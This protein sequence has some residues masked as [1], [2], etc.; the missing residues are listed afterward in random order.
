MAK[1]IS[2][3]DIQDMSQDWGLDES[4]GLPYSG[5]AVQKFIK[6]KLNSKMGW[7]HYD[8]TSNRYL[9]FADE[10]SKDAYVENPTRTDLV[11]GTFDAPF[12][13]EASIVLE[14]SAYNA[15]SLGSTGHYIDFTFDI[16]NKTG[17]STGESV[18]CTYTFRRGSVKQTV[19]EQ[20][21][22]GTSVHFNVDKYLSEGT[23]T[24]I[25]A[26]R[27]T[28]TLAATTASVTYQVVN[29]SISTELD[30]SQV[31][32][33]TQG[34]Q[35]M[36]VPFSV[37]GYGTKTV[38]WYLDGKKQN[39]VKEE[40][41]VV[42]VSVSR[43][44]Y[45]TLSN[46]SQ[47]VHTLQ[48]RAGTTVE[49]DSFY[50]D[51]LYREILVYTNTGIDTMTA[52]AM[53]VPAKH[54][55]LSSRKLYGMVQYVPYVLTFATYTPK[56]AA[57]DVDV[58]IDGVSQGTVRSEN[59]VVNEF[60][61]A[62]SASGSATIA[63]VT[64]GGSSSIGAVI[65][66]TTLNISEIKDG[67][68]LNFRAVGKSNN[69]TDKDSWSDGDYSGT[70]DGFN[71][72]NTSGWVDNSLLINA[73]ASFGI[74]LAP[75]NPNPSLLG[76]TIEI[77][78][79]TTNVHND[80]AVICDLRGEN[81][82]GILITATKV[83]LTSD[84]GVT[85]DTPFKDNEVNRFAFVINKAQGTTNKCMSFIYVNGKV[86]RG[87]AWAV[88]DRYATSKTLLFRGTEDAEIKL[89]AIRI[90]DAALTSDQLL[91]NYT[92]YRDN[93]LDMN[94]VYERN[95]VYA[96]GT[97]TFDYEKMVGR[98]PV[99]IVTGNIPVLENTTDKNEQITVDIDYHNIQHPELSFSWKQAAFRP[100]GTS[101]MG[102]PKKNFRPY[103]NKLA[104]TVCYDASGNKVEDRL[105]AFKEGA[106]RV[107]CWCLKADYAESSGTHNT[108][109]ARLWNNVLMNATVDGKYVFRTEA[110]K[111]AVAAGF[112]YDVRTTIDG[113]PILLFYRLT[114][115]DPLV[116]IGKYNFNND[117]STP[118][119]F[120][121][122]GVPGFDNRNMQCWEVLN[123][124][125]ALALF[126]TADGFDTGWS[127]AFESRYP[128]TKNPDTTK[129]KA[130]C[131]WMS[132]VS[133]TNF[134]TQKWD[135]FNV[136][137]LAAYYVYLMRFGAVD[138][139][140]K[141]AMLT[142]EDGKH[143][144]F[145]NYD[146]D[147]INGLINTGKLAVPWNADRK[148]IGEDG[149]PY[150]AGSQSRLWN[151]CEADAEFMSVVSKV[152]EALYTAGLKYAD[153]VKMF[154][155]EQADK[156]VER[157]YNQDAQY[158]YIGPYVEKGID[159]LFM[160]Q[161]DRSTHRKWWLARR[162]N[163]FDSKFI[164]GAYKAQSVEL[165]CINNTT[166][167]QKITITAGTAM[168]Y[169]YGINNVAREGN[170]TLAEGEQHTFTTTETVNLGDPIRLYAAANIKGIDLSKMTDRLAVV[171]IDKVY[172][173]ALG[174]K[175]THLVVGS[176]TLTNTSVENISGLAQAVKLEHLDVQNMKGMKALDLTGQ[177]NIRY[178][179]T[180][181]SGIGSV[182]FARGAALQTFHLSAAAKAL[183][184]VQLPYLTT[185]TSE[186]DF[187]G[188]AT[189]IV[190]KCPTLSR[191]FTFVYDWFT[192]A[193]AKAE[194]LS[195]EMDEIAWEDVD[196]DRLIEMGAIGQKSLKGQVSLKS[197]T[198]EQ[199]V[200]L[201]EIYG[202][203]C[204]SRDNDFFISAPD[205]VFIVSEDS[206]IEG[207]KLQLS[208]EIFSDSPGTV[209]W[210]IIGGGT[211]YQSIDNDGLLTTR[212]SGSART[213]TVQAR[214]VPTQGTVVHDT[215][216]ITV[217]KAV[218]PTGGTISGLNTVGGDTDFTLSVSPEGINRSYSVAWN[219]SGAGFDNGYVGIKTQN[220][221][222]CTVEVLSDDAVGDVTLNA[223][224]TCDNLQTVI[225]SKDLTIGIL[226]TMNILS[227]Q[228]TDTV[229]SA[230]KATVK[231]G[232][233]SLKVGN[234]ESIGVPTSTVLTVTFPEVEGYKSPDDFELNSGTSSFSRSVYYK[235]ELVRV[236]LSAWDG[237]SVNGK[238]VTI[239]GKSHA[240]GG[241]AIEQKVPFD[242]FYS[243]T[244]ELD[245]NY[246]SPK[247]EFTASQVRR[248]VELMY[249][250]KFGSWIKINQTI[251][252]SATMITGNINGEHIQRIRNHSHRYLGKY[253]AEGTMTI[254]QLDDENST[255]YKDGTSATLSGAEGD[256]FMKLPRFWY[257]CM[258]LATNVWTIGFYHGT[259]SPGDGWM[260]WDGNDLIGVYESYST[261]NKAYSRSGVPSTG[262]VSQ[263]SWKTYAR[264][265]G[266]GFSIVKW[267]HHCIMAA[268]YYAMYGNTNCQALIGVGTDSYS[269]SMGQTN[270]LGMEDTKAETNGNTQSINFWG[271]EN[272]WGNKS[273]WIDN[274]VVDAYKW[275]VTEDDGSERMAGTGPTTNGWISKLLF[276]ER[277]D[278]IPQEVSGS[279]TSGFCD[280][281]Y[282]YPSSSRVVRRSNGYSSPNGGV[283]FAYADGVASGAYS[284]YASRLAFRG[285][286]VEAESVAAFKAAV[287]IG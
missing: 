114:Q 33:L 170:I 116:F 87:A 152:D 186:D 52:I 192:H 263:S 98:L 169:G 30:I 127:E 182:E 205:G 57:V 19:T 178:V 49:G 219:L 17:L 181:G 247:A 220:D 153:V 125:N 86:S 165:K 226:F 216:Q 217:K 210:S 58:R 97:N 161:G 228:G 268:L 54:G 4:N 101:S 21:A 11:L 100:Q 111:A 63:F 158:K 257:R 253:T 209:T 269:K 12:N 44:K 9:C 16:R 163:Y 132:G 229:I 193:S 146:N 197:M 38:E 222:G 117:K 42:D 283:A 270:S 41:E 279:S 26:V 172:D 237:G 37:S 55:I 231:F 273:E 85:I 213:I 40:D 67:L 90:Y 65:E 145:I 48:M 28:D 113:F 254:C 70:F 110:Q 164:S 135:H 274:V 45:I 91:N 267:K 74:N 84:A 249:S 221:S 93:V 287:A 142:S 201:K 15:V 285:V 199:L 252:D 43:T 104:S 24:V 137:L 78:F 105:Y 29:L 77:E 59:G 143:F 200:Q 56:A 3:N 75:L 277:I 171:T 223:V 260:E 128:D 196:A 180:K 232:T 131:Q 129:L 206:V 198:G 191:N 155:E 202:E 176:P 147:T 123:N 144:F 214:H 92:L 160:L 73:G 275:E 282:G 224:I 195:L 80:D 190:K 264:N 183:N 23:N 119:V 71:W 47:G 241:T 60:T 157:V 134:A 61:V 255:L 242:K 96:V 168:D 239:D 238:I 115:D 211:S 159:N 103:S 27:G 66:E 208:A 215:K 265:R 68:Q 81:G 151:L 82:T 130:F 166:A 250:L 284:G 234:G 136:Y 72:N 8:T 7:F 185:L 203:N 174:T 246:M 36:A 286:L 236:T 25:I 139:T 187:A 141:N 266:T 99:M 62:T 31:Y 218:R 20:Y 50:S 102:Y 122:E 261:G 177:S 64:D 118:S 88:T 240:W 126:T 94:D 230:V 262:N 233:S 133:Q 148:T 189:V 271:L 280:Y 243:I 112:G 248:D 227:N 69:A 245:D 35:V 278:L 89:K 14:S 258:E 204:F 138:Q 109:I 39:F 76:K 276:G 194:V 150:Y 10:A 140:V 106:Q 53:T 124:G 179:N 154:D 162:F 175:L 34:A 108:G 235:T 13:Y 2:E 32:D 184:L 188:I 6:E 95:N 156:W 244:T 18:V 212:E 107:D 121:F 51:T 281:Y 259:E 167:G 120:G 256:V 5:R 207:D 22:A 1:K 173:E 272:W 251:T 225:V 83:V 149:Q 46:L 79:A